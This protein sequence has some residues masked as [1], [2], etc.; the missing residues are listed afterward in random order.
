MKLYYKL[1]CVILPAI[2]IAACSASGVKEPSITNDT[3]VTIME[4]SLQT[5]KNTQIET[6]ANKVD[7][8]E[9]ETVM[10]ESQEIEK[11]PLTQ[12]TEAIEIKKSEQLVY[13]FDFDK[14]EIGQAAQDSLQAHADYLIEN[15]NT[16][17]LVKGHSD[18]QGNSGYNLFLSKERAKKVAQILIDDGVPEDQIKIAGLGDSQ[19]LNDVN[20]FKKNRWVELQYSDSRVATK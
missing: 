19:P 5:D 8:A 18:T 20:S 6:L 13:Q 17:L 1:T 2:L 16:I 12:T 3:S 9:T 10:V 4:P 14:Q 11:F 15:P 7:P